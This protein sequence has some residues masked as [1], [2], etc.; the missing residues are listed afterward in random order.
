MAKPQTL[1]TLLRQLL[2]TPDNA[3][4]RVHPPCIVTISPSKLYIFITQAYRQRP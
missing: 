4:K 1:V 3:A 2:Q